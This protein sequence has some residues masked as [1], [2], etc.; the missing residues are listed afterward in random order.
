MLRYES[1]GVMPTLFLGKFYKDPMEP[2][3]SFKPNGVL[4]AEI[5]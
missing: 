5:S 4:I 1:E 2:S 3:R